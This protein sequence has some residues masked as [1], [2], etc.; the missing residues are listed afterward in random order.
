MKALC[1]AITTQILFALVIAGSSA[2]SAAPLTSS[3]KLE[4]KIGANKVDDVVKTLW[5][6]F[7][8]W[9]EIAEWHPAVRSCSEGKEGEATF[10][11]LSLKDGGKIK[12]KLLSSGPS[13]YRYVIVDSPLPVTNYEA[14]FSVPPDAT[15][16]DEVDISWSAAYDAADGKSEQD[17]RAAIDAIFKDGMAS[18]KTKVP[19][20]IG[21]KSDAAAKN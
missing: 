2:A 7:G 6:R 13:T 17:A 18:I 5:D 21:E 14:Q 20:N 12:E 10:R 11:N 4:V 1:S 9:C 15:T 19:K 3:Q 16:T 8:P